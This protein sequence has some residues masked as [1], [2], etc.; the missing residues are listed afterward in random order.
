[1]AVT[2]HRMERITVVKMH[3]ARNDFVLV[4]ARRAPVE[5]EAQLARRLCDRRGGI[6]AD[7]LLL[8]EPSRIA[9]SRMRIFN[10]DGTQAEMC[11]NGIRC[12]A[13]YLDE[14]G[15]GAL[16]AIET[17]AGV[18]ETRVVERE[19]T[20]LVRVTLG[21]PRYEALTITRGAHFVDL[22]HPHVVILAGVVGELDLEATALA[23]QGTPTLP[24]GGNVHEMAVERDGLR[25][26]HWERGAGL[27]QACGT[28]AV[29][30]AVV[31]IERKL[32]ASPVTVRV[33]GGELRVE[34]DGR[35]PAHLT[36]PATRVFE[37][38]M[39]PW[40]LP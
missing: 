7:G 11:G 1:M 15:A 32:L 40:A 27:T 34:W 8:V 14:S 28:G 12:V 35:G 5:R 9:G 18:I 17:Q 37:T 2:V 21:I 22:G 25:V 38:A 10:A 30:C 13:R 16:Q 6:G 24:N 36:G 26:R 33:P 3:G 23:L 31:A 20:Y 39:D 19:P 4:D 29:A